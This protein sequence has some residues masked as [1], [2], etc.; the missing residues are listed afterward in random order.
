MRAMHVEHSSPEE[1]YLDISQ[2]AVKAV[3]N[4]KSF[5]TVLQEPYSQEVLLKAK[6]SRAESNE[7]IMTWLVTQHP[8]WLV[9]LEDDTKELRLDAGLRQDGDKQEQAGQEDMRTIILKFREENTTVD[10][11]IDQERQALHVGQYFRLLL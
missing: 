3:T 8:K 1:L 2:T 11:T 4:I 9:K 7:G 6:K 5:T 10:I